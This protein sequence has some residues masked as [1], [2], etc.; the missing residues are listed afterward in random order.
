MND[1]ITS[2]VLFGRLFDKLH[3]EVPEQA[4][5]ADGSHETFGLTLPEEDA[6]TAT[7]VVMEMDDGRLLPMVSNQQ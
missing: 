2:G 4:R 3:A 7:T 5:A 1:G 6:L